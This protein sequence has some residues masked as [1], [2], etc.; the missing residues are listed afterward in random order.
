MRKYKKHRKNN[1]AYILE[2]MAV[3]AFLVAI[4]LI[5]DVIHYCMDEKKSTKISGAGDISEINDDYYCDLIIP[6]SDIAFPV[7]RGTDNLKYLHTAV[8]GEESE[9]GAIFMDYRCDASELPHTIIYGHDAQGVNGNRLMFGRL[10]YFLEEDFLQ[11]HTEICI[12]KDDQ[13]KYYNIFAIKVTDINDEAYNLD[14]SNETEFNEFAQLM[15]A[16]ENTKEILTLSTCLGREN[17]MRLLVQ[18]ALVD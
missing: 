13:V 5:P 1:S 6:G 14:F 15:G 16:P 18:G 9:L 11:N 12:C 10:R 8:T 7:M 2:G 4:M 17:N 3:I